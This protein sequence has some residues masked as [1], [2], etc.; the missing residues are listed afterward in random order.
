[1]EE[2]QEEKAN[3]NSKKLRI[4]LWSCSMSAL[5]KNLSVIVI[6]YS[7]NHCIHEVIIMSCHVTSVSRLLGCTYVVVRM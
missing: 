1:V 7:G 3:D 5:E 2:E 6:L 4:K